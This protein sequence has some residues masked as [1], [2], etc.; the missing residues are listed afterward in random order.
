MEINQQQQLPTHRVK[1]LPISN[2]K[3]PLILRREQLEET[4]SES[5]NQKRPGRI[6]KGQAMSQDEYQIK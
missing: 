3:S 2:N 5:F 4:N 1:D 6:I